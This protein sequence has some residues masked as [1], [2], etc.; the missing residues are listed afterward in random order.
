MAA[1]IVNVNS[2]GPHRHTG[3][4]PRGALGEV[5]CV[6]HSD[7]CSS[8]FVC[9]QYVGQLF[10]PE[11]PLTHNL[12]VEPSIISWN[13]CQKSFSPLSLCVIKKKAHK[14]RLGVRG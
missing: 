3:K 11:Y 13:K 2:L 8:T 9:F 10:R 14:D 5:N 1:I 12:M 4:G 6:E 7:E